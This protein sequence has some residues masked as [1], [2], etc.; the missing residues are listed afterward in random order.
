MLEILA[1]FHDM[2]V[3]AVTYSG[4]GEPLIY[5]HI[6]E[7]L[8]KTLEYE[9][10]LS[11]ITNG[12][13]LS[14]KAAGILTNA[15]WVR[16]S[17]NAAN[18]KTFSQIR[19]RPEKWFS[20]LMGNIE[21][22]AKRKNDSCVLGI[23]FVVNHFNQEEVYEAAE[24]YKRLGANNIKFTPQWSPN[25]LEYHSG[26]KEKVQSQIQKARTKLQDEKFKVYDT[27][28]KDFELTGINER[29]YKRCYIMQ[30]IPVVGA[31][32]KVYFCH[33]KAYSEDGCLGTIK[34]KSF[35]EL[36]FSEESKKI[37]ESFNPSCGC[38][39]QCTNDLKNI[40]IRDILDCHSKGVNFV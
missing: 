22:F 13:N 28:E 20:E 17:S 27:Y 9:I 6:K 24:L 29:T 30:T 2:G 32:S 1:D 35:R 16:V 25:F 5:P 36:W 4:G 40:L 39:H 12:Q 3:K 14:G 7:I 23:N 26:F 15:H 34:N 11:M 21:D 18:G 37:F 33:N 31:D 38:K 8:E 10:D 19:K